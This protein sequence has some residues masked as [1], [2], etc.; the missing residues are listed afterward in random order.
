M[1]V[2]AAGILYGSASLVPAEDD[3]RIKLAR[4]LIPVVPLA[5]MGMGKAIAV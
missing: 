2:V 3:D 4:L 1:I 5:L